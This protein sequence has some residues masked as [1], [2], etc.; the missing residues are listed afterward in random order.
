[1]DKEKERQTKKQTLSYREQTDG[2]QRG[3]G[4]GAGGEIG[5][6]IK[7][8]LITMNAMYRTVHLKLIQHCMLIIVEFKKTI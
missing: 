3:S 8:T 7:N 1:M 6:G 5:E 2:Y 4:W